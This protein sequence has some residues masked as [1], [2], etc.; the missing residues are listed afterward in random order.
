MIL[1]NNDDKNIYKKVDSSSDNKTMKAN[2]ITDSLNS[3]KLFF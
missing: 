1:K 3:M 2:Q